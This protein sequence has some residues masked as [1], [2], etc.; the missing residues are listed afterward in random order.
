MLAFVA[1]LT[2]V[3]VVALF[4]IQKLLHQI[5]VLKSVKSTKD[6]I[7]SAQDDFFKSGGKSGGVNKEE[8]KKSQDQFFKSGG[9]NN[10]SKEK[11]QEIKKSQDD[12]FKSGGKSK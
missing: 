10:I 5:E 6:K 11:V 7:K 2:V 8:V 12:F 4:F 3:I 1:V 9:Q